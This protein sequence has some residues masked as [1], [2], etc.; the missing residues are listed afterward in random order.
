MG[1]NEG[2]RIKYISFIN[3]VAAVAVL[4][5][6]T[7]NCF[8]SFSATELYWKIANV[9]ESVFYFAVPL[10]FMVSGIT[11]MDFYDRDTI[12]TYFLKRFRKVF[13]PFIAWSIIGLIAKVSIHAIDIHDIT[14]KYIYEGIVGTKIVDIYWFFTSLF[15]LYL[16]MPLIAAVDKKKRKEV[17]SYAVI[18]GFI[19]NQ[20]VPFIKNLFSLDITTPYIVIAVSG[21]L[22]WPPLGWL[23][24]TCELSRKQ[25]ALIYSISA[26]GLLVHITGTYYLSMK[27]GHVVKVFK[28]YQNVPSVLYSVG[29][30]VF[31]KDIGNRIMEGKAAAFINWFSKYTFSIYLMQFILLDRLPMLPFVDTHS[32]FYMLG[33]PFAIIPIIILVTWCLRKIPGL[34]VILP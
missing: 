2:R 18:V 29:V 19:L 3:A 28:G 7:N 12:S 21:V 33:A 34:K 24:H 11:L 8:W 5:L 32:V 14:P 20:V 9:I 10:F 22:L 4:T 31:L 25:K 16:S 26:F 13:I 15:I 27:A 17:F 30:F 23:L 6:H 1:V